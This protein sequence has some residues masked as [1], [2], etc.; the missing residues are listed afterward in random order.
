VTVVCRDSSVSIVTRR[1]DARPTHSLS[2]ASKPSNPISDSCWG[3]GCETDRSPA[4]NAVVQNAWSYT[5]K[6]AYTCVHQTA[7]TCQKVRSHVL[8]SFSFILFPFIPSLAIPA[9]EHSA[10]IIS[11]PVYCLTLS[12]LLVSPS[13]LSYIRSFPFISF[14]LFQSFIPRLILSLFLPL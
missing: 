9:S 4:S 13:F 8:L 12:L 2:T 14:S 6:Y 10:I 5:S 7:K 1:R 11:S 3:G